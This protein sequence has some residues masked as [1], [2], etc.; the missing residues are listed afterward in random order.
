MA[1]PAS[2]SSDK[3]AKAPA[4]SNAA[5]TRANNRAEVAMDR[6]K[7]VLKKRK[8]DKVLLKTVGHHGAQA[9][10]VVGTASAASYMEGRYGSDKLKVA[11]Y[12]VRAPFGVLLTAGGLATEALT[13]GHP[14]ASYV[15]AVGVGTMTS[16]SCSMAFQAGQKAAQKAGVRPG[17]VQAIAV[18]AGSETQLLQE[19]QATPESKAAGARGGRRPKRRIEPDQRSPQ[20]PPHL[21]R[22]LREQRRAA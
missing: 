6:L 12:D 20:M 9:A 22:I 10:T 11:G 2:T 7:N 1:S 16:Y 21:A 15:T 8:G 14:A 5:V 18:P 17:A 4:K 19:L 3:S 13:G